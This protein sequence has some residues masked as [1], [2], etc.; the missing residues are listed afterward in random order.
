MSLVQVY[1]EEALT[2]MALQRKDLASC[3][4]TYIK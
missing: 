4:V 1:K 3:H 2:T